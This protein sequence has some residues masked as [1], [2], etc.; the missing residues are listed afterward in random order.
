[1]AYTP[2]ALT[3]QGLRLPTYADRL[4][5]LLASY[6]EI[7]GADA[8]LTEASP[9]YQ[10]LSVFARALDDF[11][12]LL[13]SLY[14]ARNP[15]YATGQALDLLLP[16]FGL[17]RQG[18]SYS[19]VLLTL[20][21]TPDAVLPSAP[22]VLDSAGRVWACQ[23]A[24]IPLDSSGTATVTALCRTPGPIPAPA[25]TL[26]EL[27]APVPG[28][29]SVVNY[30][31]AVPGTDAEEDDDARARLRRAAEAPSVT[32]LQ[33]LDAALRRVPGVRACRVAENPTASTDARGLPPHSFCAVLSGGTNVNIARAIYAQKAPGIIP[34]GSVTVQVQDPWG[35]P[36]PI[37]FRR[38][39]AVYATLTLE[40]RALEGFDPDSMI[41]AVKAA[42]INAALRL[43]I[44]QSLVLPSLY[45]VVYGAVT[46]AVPAFSVSLLTATVNGTVYTDVVPVSW[47]G[48]ILIPESLIHISVTD[49]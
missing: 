4:E 45:G 15:D 16:L 23:T 10:L 31:D 6:R 7:F 1:M 5:A 38:A 34:Y 49:S 47:D 39:A 42:L 27:V 2:P 11:S 17:T 37:S 24:G 26:R 41:P 3:P 14:N 12:S 43:D 18:A 28:L 13:L 36:V 19:S 20:S 33:G 25:G 40:L 22:E 29:S 9:D 46:T 32:L 48:L 44:G 8:V 35:N 21:G 30:T